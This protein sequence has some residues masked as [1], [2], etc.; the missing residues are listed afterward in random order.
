VAL[1]GVGDYLLSTSRRWMYVP[2]GG[3]SWQVLYY[4][5]PVDMVA[6]D[7]RLVCVVDSSG[8]VTEREEDNNVSV[9]STQEYQVRERFIDL[10]GSFSYFS[11]PVNTTPGAWGYGIVG[12]H[13][14]GSVA[15]WGW[16]SLDMH[17][18][19]DGNLAN[20]GST[21]MSTSRRWVYVPA[22]G[23]S[24]QVV[25][26]N[27]PGGLAT[28]DYQLCLVVDSAGEFT[29]SNETNNTA[30][31]ATVHHVAGLGGTP[32]AGAPDVDSLVA[33]IVGF[34]RAYLGREPDAVGLDAWVTGARGGMSLTTIADAFARS[35]E[36]LAKHGDVAADASDAT[37]V[38][39]LY[40]TVLERSASQSEIDAWVVALDAG[41]L[42]R[43]DVMTRFTG[44][45]EYRDRTSSAGSPAPDDL[46]VGVLLEPRLVTL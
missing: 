23:V 5:L 45:Q 30:A 22:G 20:G 1:D 4:T 40:R 18:D 32:L 21:F 10:T 44:S 29:E 6:D 11:L 27:V 26:Y 37:F 2:A 33:P 38:T 19:D 8:E 15:T 16:I 24:W 25:Y 43:A 42:S 36:F 41:G 14:G 12:V 35:D 7:Y 46:D 31:R 3:S 13:N 39:W 17:V 28:G 34:Y 9:P